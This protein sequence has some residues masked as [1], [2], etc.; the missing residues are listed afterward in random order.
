MFGRWLLVAHSVAQ[1]RMSR[2]VPAGRRRW[3]SLAN[4]GCLRWLLL[5]VQEPAPLDTRRREAYR[6]ALRWTH[7]DSLLWAARR[8]VLRPGSATTMHAAEVSVRRWNPWS[9]VLPVVRTIVLTTGVY[10]V[11]RLL[12]VD[13]SNA[14]VDGVLVGFLC[15]VILVDW[16][17]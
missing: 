6:E 11:E 13:A 12:D 14:L 9:A 1:I 4:A 3:P 7:P 5:A 17:R 16:K 2:T 15:L 8:G 10:T